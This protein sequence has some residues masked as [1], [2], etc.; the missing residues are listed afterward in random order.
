MIERI[1]ITGIHTIIDDRLHKYI[2]KKIGGLDHYIPRTARPSAHAE[3]VIRQEK[4]SENK[5]YLCEITLYVPH[6]VLNISER[7]PNAFSAVDVAE[8]KMKQQIVI[9]KEKHVNGIIG[10]RLAARSV[11]KESQ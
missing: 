11:R 1:E 9:Y 6:E 3:I 8:A 5:Q 10:R 7:M 2:T 4:S